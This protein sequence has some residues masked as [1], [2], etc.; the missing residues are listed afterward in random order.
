M[1]LI[2]RVVAEVGAYVY[3]PRRQLR[4]IGKSDLSTL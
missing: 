4:R 2:E 1:S 3:L